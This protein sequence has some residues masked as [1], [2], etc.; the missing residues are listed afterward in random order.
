MTRW[1]ETLCGKLDTLKFLAYVGDDGFPW[2]IPVVPAVA[3]GDHRIVFARTTYRSELASIP[4]GAPVALFA[5]NMQMESVLLR[6]S[7]GVRPAG[8]GV[9][10]VDWVY[11]TMPPKPGQIFPP[12]PL[13]PV[14]WKA[15]QSVGAGTTAASS[16]PA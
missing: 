15:A 5:M 7:Y 11:N 14:K 8:L 1:S 10:D 9:I 3:A 6:G 2:I 12:I 4:N 16:T 13:R